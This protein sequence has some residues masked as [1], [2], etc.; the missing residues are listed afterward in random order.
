MIRRPRLG[1]SARARRAAVSPTEAI[2]DRAAI[3]VTVGTEL[4]FDRLIRTVDA[5]AERTGR[6]SLVFAQIGSSAFEPKH[7]RW[8]PHVDNQVF[9]R[10]FAEAD[11]IVAHAGMGTVIA[12]L[13]EQRPLVVVPRR[14]ALGEHRNDHQL[15]TVAHLSERGLVNVAME[16]S[17]VIAYLDGDAVAATP[18]PIGAM[19][20]E[21]LLE[22]VRLALR[23]HEPTS[24]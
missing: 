5:W 6:G 19:A 11:L 24:T 15:A 10:L 22:A 14:A 20:D 3:F 21:R 1:V 2:P 18:P 16:A 7:I 12:A 8:A 17:D 23:D 4:P 13:E 9:R